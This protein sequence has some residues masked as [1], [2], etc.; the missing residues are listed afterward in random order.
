MRN[1]TRIVVVSP[2]VNDIDVGAAQKQQTPGGHHD[3]LSTGL[4]KTAS[5][6]RAETL[7]L[8]RILSST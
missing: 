6:Q 8:L 1:R 7:G 2:G 4:H 3:V 5:Q